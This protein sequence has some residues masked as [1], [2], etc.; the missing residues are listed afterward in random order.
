MLNCEDIK[1]L[2]LIQDAEDE[3][4]K[5]ASY[6][7]RVG[8]IITTSDGKEKALYEIKPNSL[9]IAISKEKVKLPS[10][11]I[12][13][14]YVKT[15]LSQRGIMANNIGIIDP[16]YEGHLS[17]VLV[18][19]GQR[20]HLLKK[21]DIF[22]RITFTK[23]SDTK[24]QIAPGT[25]STEDYVNARKIDAAYLGNSFIDIVKEVSQEAKRVL[26]KSYAKTVQNLL[27]LLTVLGLILNAFNP[28]NKK[29]NDVTKK[30]VENLQNQ[31]N[32]FNESQATIKNLENKII[33]LTQEIDSISS[34][35][36][37]LKKEKKENK[38]DAHAKR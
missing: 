33:Y 28:S 30:Q 8:K 2:N 24:E 10:N 36:H 4:F 35:N 25:N 15:T 26:D 7:L 20:V 21:N 11:I 32:S 13:H 12:G 6:D 31:I 34:K 14:A 29:I 19:F 1:K 17:S 5:N 9:T 27:L 37:K 3:N 22:L 16:G 38:A 18:N 23:I